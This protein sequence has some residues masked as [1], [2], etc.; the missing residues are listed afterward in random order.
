M[1]IRFLW[2]VLLAISVESAVELW[3]K[4]APLQ[5]IKRWIVSRTP[6]LYSEEMQTHL[7]DCPYCVSLWVGILAVIGYLYMDSVVVVY[8][9]VGLVA[10]RLSNYFHILF[11]ILRDMQLDL[12]IRRR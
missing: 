12:R 5:G 1:D 7:C 3:K 6:F 4:A 10:H 2:I 11:S 9:V 8:I